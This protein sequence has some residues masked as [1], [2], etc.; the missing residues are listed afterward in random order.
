MYLV[1][2]SCLCKYSV[3]TIVGHPDIMKST[4]FLLFLHNL[5][6]GSS[7]FLRS[8][9]GKL[10]LRC[11]GPALPVLNLLF[12]TRGSKP[13]ADRCVIHITIFCHLWISLK[14]TII[15][16]IIIITIDFPTCAKYGVLFRL[17]SIKI[18]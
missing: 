10:L 12:K 11:F 4:V 13:L 15:I 8:L 6:L 16:T 18:P 1:T 7:P 5:H 9:I 3:F 14:S 2:P 17:H